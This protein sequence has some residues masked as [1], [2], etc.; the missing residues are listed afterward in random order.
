MRP[1]LAL[2]EYADSIR[3]TDCRSFLLAISFRVLP[4]NGQAEKTQSQHMGTA[5]LMTCN[6]AHS[7]VSNSLQEWPSHPLLRYQGF[8]QCCSA[9]RT[10]TFD[11]TRFGS[12]ASVHPSRTSQ[13]ENFAQLESFSI[14]KPARFE[15]QLPPLSI[16]TLRCLVEITTE[17]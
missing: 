4:D 5:S 11:L 14:S 10:D 7:N 1:A 16:T 3:N 12:G 2:A 17:M 9:G 15:Y 8:L 13:H 6:G